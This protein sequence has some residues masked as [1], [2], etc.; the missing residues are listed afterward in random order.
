M[1]GIRVEPLDGA[2]RVRRRESQLAAA[3]AQQIACWHT[4]RNDSPGDLS[5]DA[6]ARTSAGLGRSGALLTRGSRP[7]AV[8]R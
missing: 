6:G 5:W 3:S 2:E 8:C 7:L 1:F 4:M